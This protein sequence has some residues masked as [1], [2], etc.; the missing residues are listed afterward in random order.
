MK[1]NDSVDIDKKKYI[2]GIYFHAEGRVLQSFHFCCL[3]TLNHQEF[4]MLPQFILLFISLTVST[5]KTITGVFN[6]FDSLTWTRSVEYVYKGPETPTWNAVLGWSLNSTTA[7]PGDTFNL[8]LPCV[9]KFITTQ[10]SVDLTADGVSY[11][12]CDFNAGEEFTTFSSLSCT[13]NSV[14]V[15]YARV[16]GTVKLP[17]TFNVG[18]TG[19]SVDLADS[20]CFTAGKNTVTFMDGDTK[21]S[22][23][24]DFD[25]SPVSPSGYITSSR[26]IPS[27]NKLS[28]LFVVPQCENGYT[29][30]I[31]GFV[32]S[33]GATID[34]SNINI[35]ISKGLND[36]NFPVSSESFSY[37]KT[38]TSTSITVEFQNV[39]AGYRPFVDAYISAENIDKYTLTYANEYT[40]E[41]GNTVVDPF[42]LTWWG[43][44][45]SEADS[46]GD[47]IVVTTRTVTD[48]TTAVTTLP[49]NPSVDKTETIEILQPI[50]T[51]TITT[52][53]IGISTSYETLTGTI[54]GTATVIV[55]T[56][57]HIT[58]TVTNFWTGSITTTTTYTNPTGSIDTVIVQIPLPD[59]TTTITEFWSESFASTTTITNPPD[60]TNSVIVKEPHNPTVTTTEFWSES[61]ASTTT[62]TNPPDG[63]NSVIVKEPYNP[64]VTTTEFW[65]E[66]FASTTTITNPPDG[67]NSVIIK[68][69]YNP[70][71]TTTEF[72]SES[73]ASTTPSVS[74]FE[75][76][77]FHSSEPHYSSDFDSSDS[78]VTLISVTT[79]SSYDESSTIVSSTFPTLHLS[80]YTWSSGLVPPVTFPRY[81]NTTI[82]NLPTFESSSVYSS[83]ASAVASTDGDSVVPSSTNLVT[84]SS[85]SS[86]T[87]CIDI[88][89]CSSVRQ[90]S[91]VMVTPSNSGRIIISDSAYLTTTYLH[92]ELDLESIVTVVQTKSSDWSLSSGNSHKPESATTVSDDNSYSLST[93]GPSSSEYSILFTS[94]KEGHVSSYVPRVSYTS[95][96]KVS[97]SSTMSS[98]NGMSATHTFGISTNTIPSST[99]TSIKSATVTTPVSES[100][101]TGMSIFMSTTTESKTTDITTETSVSGEVNLGS[102]TVKVS[103]SEFISKGTVTRIM[104][105]ELTNSESTFT[106][107]PSFVLTSTESS[108]IETPATIEMSSRS[109]SYSVPLSKL[110]SE[111]E[112]T[113]VIPTSSTATGS[114][115]IGSP[116]SV[117]TSNESIITGSSSF[118][119]TT[120]ESIATKTIVSET[121]V[122]KV[123][124]SKSLAANASPSE[125]TSKKETAETIS[126][127]SI[128]TESIVAGSP[129]LVLTTTVLDTTETTITETSIVGELSSRSLTFKASSLSKGE[130]TGTVTPEMSVSTSKATTGT[131]SEVSIKES[132][133]TKVP[134]F[135]STTIK[136]E[137]SETQH[138][139]SRT[140]Q[141]PYSETKGSQL[142]TANS[143]VSQ[144][145]SSKSLIFESAISKDESTFVSATVKSITTPA[146][147]QYQ[148][149]LPNPAVSVS[150][151]S[152]KKL[153]IIESQTEN[154]ATQHSIYFDSIETLTLSNTLANTLVSG[155]MKNSETTSELTT[156][157][158]AIGFS[159]TTETS[160]PGATNSAL[161]P[162]VDSGKSSMLGWSGGIVSTVSTSTRL[163]DSTATLSSITAA[164]QGSLNPSTVSKYPHGSETI[165]NG[166]NGSSHSSSALASTIS[167]SHSIT[168][169]AHQTTLSQ[170]LISS[171][172][173]TV[174]ASTYDGSGSVIKLHSWFYGLVTIFFLFI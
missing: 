131:T 59:P 153:S 88:S 163:E 53:Y 121:P 24:V 85:S 165:D 21:I 171:S 89:G 170:L 95:S 78:F 91:S 148:T 13:V 110:R 152:G 64:T 157:D 47:V 35:G 104:P 168:F 101:N 29:S 65:S 137:T 51:T 116:S 93:P 172:T 43:Y 19:S 8:I 106:A 90:S 37:T 164:N 133:T 27:L 81:V 10:T 120:A 114:T 103:S 20:K 82:S 46:D 15:S 142:S 156:S 26:I 111:G 145:G 11:A 18:G 73:F 147:T 159:T 96:V 5:A 118:V 22:T 63:T 173:K 139:E 68:E 41:N 4:Q 9:F 105:T 167:A 2:K 146:V 25:A 143:Q 141:I 134:T 66:S 150:E 23:T 77:I 117:S 119:S 169:S 138:S 3:K 31:M 38:C 174:I 162:S 34:C 87:Y 149:S 128:V 154:S 129:S 60:G 12:T 151:E 79:A 58:A 44:K 49:F 16:S 48:S 61:F 158:K 55:D 54:G 144:T 7:D 80:S 62:I 74:S 75:S 50:P 124:S 69:P 56:P 113:R 84:Q 140:T 6:S 52:S 36:W 125:P 94:E 76:T 70:T 1:N 32:A 92:S 136:P 102:A 115:V 40:C 108:V 57:Y 42:T 122:T 130:I 86:E 123:L 155:A 112:T 28:S 161:S 100:T 98:E 67:T 160:I 126:T 166:S 14:S 17:I 132:L 30:G 39:P 97:I 71:V 72:W 127:R 83:T 135:T 107:S 33:N 99:E 45:N 109:S